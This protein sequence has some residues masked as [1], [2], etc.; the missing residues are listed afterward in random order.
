VAVEIQGHDMGLVART[1][2][3]GVDYWVLDRTLTQGVYADEGRAALVRGLLQMASLMAIEVE[4]KGVD[5]KPD[6]ETLV[7]AGV[8][9][10]TGPVAAAQRS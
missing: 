2:E 10:L 6:L 1:H 5:S 9:Y 3:A 7:A 8:H 4:A